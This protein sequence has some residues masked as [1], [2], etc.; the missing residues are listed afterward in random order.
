MGRNESEAVRTDNL[1]GVLLE[2]REK[3][4]S[5]QEEFF[6]LF[7]CLKIGEIIPCFYIDE[8]DPAKKTK[9]RNCVSSTNEGLSKQQ[10]LCHRVCNLF[11]RMK[12]TKLSLCGLFSNIPW[13]ENIIVKLRAYEERPV[14]SILLSIS[15]PLFRSPSLHLTNH[16]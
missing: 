3:I 4:V 10:G 12:I 16:H 9:L 2:R 13:Y 11:S 8:N 7:V 15:V 5:W 1:L 6:L 14:R